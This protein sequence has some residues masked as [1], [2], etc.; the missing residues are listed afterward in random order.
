[1]FP[2]IEKFSNLP[3][4]LYYDEIRTGDLF[5]VNRTG[6]SETYLIRHTICM[7]SGSTLGHSGIFIWIDGDTY[8]TQ[9]IVR[10]IGKHEQG[11]ILCILHL[12][13]ET[14]RMDL[15]TNT[16]KMGGIVLEPFYDNGKK[17]QIK[18]IYSR[19]LNRNY[20]SETVLN[21]ID[22]FLKQ[23]GDYNSS[24]NFLS[25]VLSIVSGIGMHEKNGFTCAQF[26]AAFYV[27]TFNYPYGLGNINND[28]II[29]TYDYSV[30]QPRDFFY[31]YNKSPVFENEKEYPLY[32][33]IDD[34]EYLLFNPTILALII[35][36]LVIVGFAIW[37]SYSLSNEKSF[38]SFLSIKNNGRTS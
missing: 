2:D 35:L 13:L 4:H 27:K 6:I 24:N 5:A 23:A 10:T 14:K 25:V 30:Y 36:I 21:N 33:K 20:S 7:F 16:Y 9:Q 11:A 28:F 12:V 26:T 38:S 32:R 17:N 22:L 29:P 1:M 19:K 37:I 8:K 31:D 15:L 3:K 18:M 34:A